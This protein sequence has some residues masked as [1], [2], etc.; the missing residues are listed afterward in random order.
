MEISV[1]H[2][3]T[4][5]VSIKENGGQWSEP[6]YITENVA[7]QEFPCVVA[8]GNTFYI[9]YSSYA[10]SSICYRTITTNK[11]PQVQLG[12]CAL[13]QIEGAPGEFGGDFNFLALVTDGNGQSDVASVRA[14]DS[15]TGA[16][17]FSLYDDGQHGD[18]F[19]GDSIY[20]ARLSQAFYKPGERQTILIQATDSKN[21]TSDIYPLLKIH[22]PDSSSSDYEESPVFPSWE[23]EYQKSSAIGDG[24]WAVYMGGYLDTN[25]QVG[26]DCWLDILAWVYPLDLN[27]FTTVDR[28]ELM[29]NDEPFM[30]LPLM[31]DDDTWGKFY[32]TSIPIPGD[33]LTDDYAN[34]V[35]PPFKSGSSIPMAIRVL[36]GRI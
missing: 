18:L 29:Y 9:F 27:T 30:T 31:I 26:C 3:K 16:P 8:S 23:S 34:L 36:S 11:P 1:T 20:S 4:S 5:S 6:Q 10:H 13:T 22:G 17:L 15:Q 21:T 24:D 32:S 14:L 12:G 35:L 2:R 25:L 33:A 19:P 7:Q 28:V